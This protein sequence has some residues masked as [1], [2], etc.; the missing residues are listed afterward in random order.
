MAWTSASA[1]CTALV[2]APLRR[3]SEATK[4]TRPR[5]C[6]RSRRTRPTSTSSIPA[7]WS[8]AG[9]RLIG[10]D[11]DPLEPGGARDRGERHRDRDGRAIGIRDQPR[12][13]RELGSVDLRHHERDPGLVAERAAVV[14]HAGA[15]GARD[16]RPLL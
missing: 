4:N 2:A 1:I 15:G 13:A 3:L 11:L 5:G 7:A 6:E 10:G 8:G 9:D 16:R 12:Q 14:D